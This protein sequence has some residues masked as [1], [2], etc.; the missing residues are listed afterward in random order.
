[1]ARWIVHGEP[2]YA[3]YA[4]TFHNDA[5]FND[6][7]RQFVLMEQHAR[8]IG[9][10]GMAMV[11]ALDHFSA[12]HPGRDSII[13]ILN[14]FTKTVAAYQDKTSG[15]WL[16]ILDKPKEPKNY[17]EASTSSMFVYALLKGARKGYLPKSMIPIGKKGY[18]GIVSK[19]IKV[20][21]GQMN[22]Y[23]TV[24]VSGLG[25]KPFCII[26]D[27]DKIKDNTTPNYMN[28]KDAGEIADWVKNGGTLL[29]MANE[30]NNCDLSHLNI[31]AG[32]FGMQF[33]KK[34]LYGKMS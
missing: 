7:T 16:N 27:P 13:Q 3:E 15:L 8:A 25:G 2:F 18:D 32:K 1:V 9:F 20:E 11:D 34:V 14:R 31:L 28:E 23:G 12:N 6:I 4:A 33:T 19:F 10:Y 22:L 5:R 26:V 30:S 29:M 24:S 17:F 21:G